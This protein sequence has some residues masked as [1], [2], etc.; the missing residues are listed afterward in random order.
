MYV[1][2]FTY[3]HVHI[4]LH[5]FSH[6]YISVCCPTLHTPLGS[7]TALSLSISLSL[8]LSPS[9]SL[10]LSLYLSLPL[11]PIPPPPPPV[12]TRIDSRSRGLIPSSALDGPR[13]RSLARVAQ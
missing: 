1:C 7:P 3:I 12:S 10:S 6:F 8:S 4:H 13:V 11:P 2:M 9:P 5:V